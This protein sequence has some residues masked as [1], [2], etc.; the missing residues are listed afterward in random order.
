MI[1]VGP[2]VSITKHGLRVGNSSRETNL[3]SITTQQSIWYYTS[4]WT[5]TS[6]VV[7]RDQL[8]A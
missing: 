1:K 5:N 7:L 4:L 8:W 2:R 6:V 3:C